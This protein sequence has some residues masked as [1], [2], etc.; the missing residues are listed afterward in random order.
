MHSI[1][2][3]IAACWSAKI[4]EHLAAKSGQDTFSAFALAANPQIDVAAYRRARN[5]NWNAF[6]HAAD[7]RGQER[8]DEVL[9]AGF[10]DELNH[11]PLFIG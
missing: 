4:S 3:F 11:D 5:A 10:A 1:S 6:K 9:L 8:Y 2:L 7:R